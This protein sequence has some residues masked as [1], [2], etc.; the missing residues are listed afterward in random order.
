VDYT[1]EIMDTIQK[2]K[3]RFWNI[4][5][6]V[7]P[8]LEHLV[9]PLHDKKRQKYHLGWLSPD[10]S[11]ADLKRHLSTKWQFGNHFV[12][13]EDTDQIL[14]WRKIVSFNEQ[15]HLRVYNDGE[16]RGHFELTPEGAPLKHFWGKGEKDRKKDFL[17]FL[18]SCVVLK[19][20]PRHLTPDATVSASSLET[21]FAEK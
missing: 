11:L 2:W 4:L 1:G 6:P 8:V 12:A 18:G 19:K 15:Y 20:Y 21:V 17:N 16:I 5:Y 9:V 7:F 14:S 13:W 3:Q 10:K